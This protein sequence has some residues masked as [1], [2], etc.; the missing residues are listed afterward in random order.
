MNRLQHETSPY[1]R[2][3]AENPVDWYPWGDEAF[4]RA[5]A[6]DKP[7]L[8]SIGYSACHWCHVMAHESFEHGPTA[9]IMN[10]LFVSVKVDR[11]ERPDVDDIYMQ[12]VIALTGHGGWPMTVFLTPDGRPFY[13]GTY[14]PVE[15]R[16]GMPAFRQILVGVA[17]AYKSRRDQVEQAASNLTEGL[18]R[19]V[20]GIGGSQTDLNADLLNVAYKRMGQEFDAANGGFS[21]APK[22]PQP[23]NLDFLLRAYA[24]TGDKQPLAQVLLTLRK[25]A[26]GGIYDQVGGGFHR[27]SV[28]A[29]WLVPHFEKMLYD[30]AQLSR[31]YLHAYQ[32]TGDDFFKTIAAEIYDYILREMTAPEG[33]FYS[34]TD[35]DSEGEEGKFFVWSKDELESLLGENARVAIEYWGI[36]SRGNFEG[37][38]ILHVPNEDEISAA[39]LNLS[40]SELHTKLNAIKDKLYAVRT[41]RVHPGLDDKILTAWNGMMLASLA[42]AA[43]IL[44]RP[45][46]RAAAVKNADFLLTAMRTPDGRLYRTHK[47]GKSK[48]NA[49]LEDYANLIDGLLELYQTTFDERWFIEAHRLADHVLD[50]F[51]AEDGGFFDTSD[52]HESLIT[53]PRN[54]QDNATPS[55]NSM[56]ARQLVRLLAYT[57]DS[58]YDESARRALALLTEA[59]RQVPGAFGEALSAV[60]ML[61]A[62]LA[63]VAIVGK[64]DDAATIA[65]LDVVRK[66]YRPNVIQA[67]TPVDI[68]EESPIPLLSYRTQRNDQPTVYVCRHFACANPVNTADAVRELLKG[69]DLA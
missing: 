66:P 16:H 60:D 14:F 5:K 34:T 62:G 53:R 37:H 39:R 45:D 41:Q 40:V 55:G 6:E 32:I 64:P 28:D 35:A 38:N 52:D 67:L 19:D 46:Y 50:H 24:R 23:M 9:T 29:I 13:G 49:Y 68:K 42:E 18:K 20:L 3:H 51:A 48:I 54:M 10:E 44:N 36:S 47:D 27:Y 57:G 26:R 33:A 11:E 21:G 59:M 12:A 17:D 56:M 8:L 58:R 1:L 31:I 63:E 61:V 4:T 15:P 2:Q 22:F 25:M 43:R 65:L 30:N 69:S 7:I